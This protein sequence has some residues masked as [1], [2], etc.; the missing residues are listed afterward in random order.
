[1]LSGGDGSSENDG[2]SESS[3]TAIVE[4]RDDELVSSL[5]FLQQQQQQP[6]GTYT[7]IHERSSINSPNHPSGSVLYNS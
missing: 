1:M 2:K 6:G 5:E 3:P 4:G 7:H